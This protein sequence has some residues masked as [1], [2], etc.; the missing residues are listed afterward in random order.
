MAIH[1]TEARNLR[2]LIIAQKAGD[3]K[4]I[5]FSISS[6]LYI[7][8]LVILRH[9]SSYKLACRISSPKTKKRTSCMKRK[10]T[11]PSV[12]PE[13]TFLKNYKT[14]LMKNSP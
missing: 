9:I 12:I 7:A 5:G 8:I 2:H 4:L 3:G 13:G 6:F 10:N 1:R 11:T 14:S